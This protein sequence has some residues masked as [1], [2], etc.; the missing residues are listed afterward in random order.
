MKKGI[1]N[2][3]FKPKKMGFSGQTALVANV[4][5]YSTIPYADIISYASK[6][7]AVPESAMTMAMEAIYDA[8]SYFVLNGHSVQVPNL[9]TF[10]ISVRCKSAATEE[11]F[12]ADFANNLRGV[13]IR[14]LPNPELKSQIAQTSIN[15]EVGDL[16]GYSSAA[17][18]NVRSVNCSFTNGF[19]LLYNGDVVPVA[20]IQQLII[21]G[22]R[23]SKDFVGTTPLTVIFL[24]PDT[25]G[26]TEIVVPKDKLHQNYESIWID[27]SVL[28]GLMPNAVYLAGV[29]VSTEGGSVIKE[30]TFTT[31]A[32]NAFAI[33]M[34]FQNS[35][36]V[37]AGATLPY[38]AGQAVNFRMTAVNISQLAA[39]LVGGA[40][41][42]ISS[43]GNGVVEFSVIPS[44]TGNAPIVCK[45]EENE[46][47]ATFNLSFGEAS[48]AS[49]VITAI[50]A[51]GD[52]L[53]NGGTTQIT[54][55][56]N[57]TLA[58]TGQNLDLLTI[59]SF[60]KPNGTT[61]VITSQSAT[62]I[63]MT[64]SNAQAGVLSCSYNGS[65]IF[66]GTLAVAQTGNV[67]VT[68]YKETANGSTYGLNIANEVES[69][70]TNNVYFVGNDLDTLTIDNF[71]ASGNGITISAY[72]AEN[73][74]LTYSATSSGSIY[75]RV[76][77]ATIATYQIQVQSD[78]GGGLDMG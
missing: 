8:M 66:S 58:I 38:V 73:A 14:F 13:Q 26:T 65:T 5:R 21:Q 41:A 47:L 2:V 39:I 69:G 53:V 70:V 19:G 43:I 40:S 62:Q 64:L 24:N 59:N 56:S 3:A 49:P 30:L 25:N 34:V 71:Q 9:G 18:I 51:N 55:G 37:L 28:R 32:A 45:N 48:A 78:N 52:P 67:T 68:G 10:S 12:T 77:N 72:D 7:S 57:Y 4:S 15:A 50:T 76:D 36:R 44:G 46:T 74:K 1:V 22:T 17:T 63:S 16:T 6:A 75:I 33:V 60:S 11:D 31:P 54:A 29:K 20:K 35:K 27:G 42:N 61:L 23:L